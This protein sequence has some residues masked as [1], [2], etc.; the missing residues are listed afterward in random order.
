MNLDQLAALQDYVRE[1]LPEIVSPAFL[2]FVSAMY[3]EHDPNNKG[4]HTT[5]VATINDNITGPWKA[6]TY[7]DAIQ[8]SAL[9]PRK[10]R[11]TRTQFVQK[12]VPEEMENSYAGIWRRPG[13]N[14]DDYP[15]E[16]YML[17]LFASKIGAVN[18]KAFWQAVAV[19][20]NVTAPTSL[21]Q[22]FDG[23][24]KQLGDS[25]TA[26]DVAPVATGGL[27]VPRHNQD[28]A[29]SG[30]TDIIDAVDLVVE[31]LPEAVVNEGVE[32]YMSLKNKQKYERA[33]RNRFNIQTQQTERNLRKNRPDL[34]S[35]MGQVNVHGCPG[36]GSSN[37]ILATP[38]RNI[39]YSYDVPSD[40]SKFNFDRQLNQFYFFGS[41]RFGATLLMKNND[42]IACNDQA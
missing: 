22:Q 38:I 20:E 9:L 31:S 40:A 3:V 12:W 1:H 29:P 41:Y 27:F 19:D 25:I 8:S 21:L 42:W 30:Q 26:G 2:T 37:R 39:R 15:Y 23:I 35:M 6:L 32:V 7:A 11:T 33:N 4:E 34:V 18:E 14:P 36:M 13:Q 24:L 17:D 10:M 28:S 16:Q 5:Q